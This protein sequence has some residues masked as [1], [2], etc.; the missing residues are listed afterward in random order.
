MPTCLHT[1]ARIDRTFYYGKS[2][3]PSRK[4]IARKL[5]SACGK[6]GREGQSRTFSSGNA[7]YGYSIA[8]RELVPNPAEVEVI[9]EIVQLRRQKTPVVHTVEVLKTRGARRRNG[10]TW[11]ARQVRP[12]L[13][14]RALYECGKIHYGEVWAE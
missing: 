14:R 6:G 13:S 8:S 7:P 3:R 4:I 1:T 2:V 11:T 12:I 10:K 5:S 9:R